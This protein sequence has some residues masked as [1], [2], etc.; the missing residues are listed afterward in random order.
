MAGEISLTVDADDL[1]KKVDT[2]ISTFDPAVTKL[3]DESMAYVW[4]K[5][6]PYPEEPV[7]SQYRRRLSGGLGGSLSTEVKPLGSDIVGVLGSN[8]E[9]GPW[10]ISTERFGDR[11]PQAWMHQGRW[12]TLQDV[13]EKAMSKV[14][15]IFQRGIQALLDK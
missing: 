14:I 12:W 7:G 9:Y 11:G 3:M 4:G 8:I 15:E 10:V 6:P 5:I 1:I 13:V 2:L